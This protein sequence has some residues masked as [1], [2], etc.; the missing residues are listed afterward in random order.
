[1]SHRDG[2]RARLRSADLYLV[3]DERL[4]EDELHTRLRSALA[5]GARV[6][7]YRAPSLKRRELLRRA[8][9]PTLHE[10]LK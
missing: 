8:A 10:L 9:D 4:P 2:L 6:V 7:Q 3:T 1:M 5:A